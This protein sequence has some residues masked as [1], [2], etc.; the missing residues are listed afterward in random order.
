MTLTSEAIAQPLV[1]GITFSQ[2]IAIAEKSGSEATLSFNVRGNMTA[3]SSIVEILTLPMKYRPKS[4]RYVSYVTQEGNIML[5]AIY[6]DGALG[7]F[8]NKK[9]FRDTSCDK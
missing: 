9:Q 3:T 2:W 6:A 8:N 4:N 1:S 5:L 7:L